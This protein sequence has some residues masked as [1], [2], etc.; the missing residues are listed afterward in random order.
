[1][2]PHV[3]QFSTL[4][5]EHR[6]YKQQIPSYGALIFNRTLDS[7]LFVIYHNPRDRIVRKLDFPKGKVDQGER[8]VNCALREIYEETQLRLHDTINVDQFVKVETIKYRM[9][10]LF[11]VEGID[12]DSVRAKPVLSEEDHDLKW[13]PVSE[14]IAETLKQNTI[15]SVLSNNANSVKYCAYYVKRFA[16][17]VSEWQTMRRMGKLTM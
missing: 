5:E 1:M 7:L 14:Y 9:V 11:F 15:D 13:I 4:Y 17:F 3:S 2:K 12:T 10:T 6:L 8:S 16:Y